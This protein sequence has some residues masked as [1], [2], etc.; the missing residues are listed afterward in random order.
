M[1]AGP[2]LLHRIVLRLSLT[3]AA[4]IVCAYSWLCIRDWFCTLSRPLTAATARCWG[5]T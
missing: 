1:K 4:A 2:S 3:T 5:N